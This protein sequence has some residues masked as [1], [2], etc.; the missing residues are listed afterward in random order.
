M[1]CA[2]N[3][4]KVN[5][6]CMLALVSKILSKLPFLSII[7][8][9]LGVRQA[10]AD[11]LS[12]VPY[13]PN[14][15]NVSYGVDSDDGQNS[16]LYT[17][18]GVLKNHRISFGYGLQD[19]TVSTSEEELDSTTY[20]VGYSY[21]SER[22]FQLGAEYEKW[23]ET[24]KIITETYSVSISFNIAMLSVS[25]SPQFRNITVYTNSQCSGDIDSEALEVELG[26]FPS[27]SWSLSASYSSYDYSQNRTRLLSCV[28]PAELY[29]VVARLQ[30]VAF[31]NQ[32]SLGFEY[33]L[34]TETYGLKW[35]QDESA[36]DGEVTRGIQTYLTTDALNDWS[37][38][39]LLGAQ[40]NIDNSTT[41]FIQ[42]TLTYYW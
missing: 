25:V 33:Y 28:D 6:W 12:I 8:I 27:D 17:N 35:A 37:I 31:D 5:L 7:I 18:L 1:R 30:T 21:Y 40:E 15:L 39:V 26:L 36:I 20:L 16:Y 9:A 41:R 10:L 11:D 23:G 32:R 22:R 34:D 42:G 24:D 38:T 2:G 14:I 19:E 4:I 13:I 29:L 3:A